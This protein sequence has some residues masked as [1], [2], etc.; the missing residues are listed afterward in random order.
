MNPIQKAIDELRFRI[1]REILRQVFRPV[2]LNWRATPVSTDEQILNT[3]IRPRVMI[4]CDIVGGTEVFISLEG[5]TPQVT[6]RLV[7]VYHIPK[8]RTD[9]RVITS[10]LSLTWVTATAAAYMSA[11]AN[12][13]P[14]SVSPLMTAGQALLNA[15][16]PTPTPSTAKVSLI[17]EN[18]VMIRDTV[19]ISGFGFLRCFLGND[20]NF[21]HLQIR[22]IPYFCR[23][24]ELATKSF[25]YNE[26]VIELDRGKVQG[27]YEIGKFKEIIE[28]YA[29]AETMYQEYLLG[30]W[31]RT[32]FMNDRE[33]HER[34][35]KLQLGGL[36]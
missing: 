30:T 15:A 29:D 17:A 28:Q 2:P 9:N 26:Y 36:R 16:G 14:C 10:V 11:D 24:V 35:I 23:L 32:A 33:A 4:D 27:G 5:L 22:S 18:T 3:V 34:F 20:E 12:F 8:D 21:S 1:P 25:I 6:D 19:G 31:S 13:K 7:T